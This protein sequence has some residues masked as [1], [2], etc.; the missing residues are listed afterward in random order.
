MRPIAQKVTVKTREQMGNMRLPMTL[1]KFSFMMLLV[2]AASSFCS[3][4]QDLIC[5]T[6]VSG[7]IFDVLLFLNTSWMVRRTT[8]RKGMVIVKSIQMSIILMYDVTGRLWERPKKL[9]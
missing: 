9:K 2:F 4:S 6:F 8:S 1:D 5:S 7:T 3:S